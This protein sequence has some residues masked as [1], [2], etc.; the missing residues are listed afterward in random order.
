MAL[1]DDLL[2]RG[3]FPRELPPQFSSAKYALRMSGPDAPTLPSTEPPKCSLCASHSV[4]RTGALRRQ[5]RIPNPVHYFGLAKHIADY[6]VQ[7]IAMTGG[8]PY[9]LTKPT[10]SGERA[11]NPENSLRSRVEHRAR[12]RATGRYLLRTDITRFYSSIYTH[13]L[14]W[15]LLGKDEAKRKFANRTLGREWSDKLD[16]FVR[17]L[18]G[19]Q[20]L[21]IPTGPDI[22][23][24]LAEVVLASID[25]AIGG[26]FPNVVGLRYIDDYE[27]VTQ[28]REEAERLLSA[29]QVALR[30]FELELNGAKTLIIQLPAA[31]TEPWVSA[32][33]HYPINP[34]RRGA[35]H[36]DLSGYFDLIF[37]TMRRYPDEQVLKYGLGRL[38]RTTVRED[39]W[40]F[41]EH[42]LQQCVLSD[43]ACLPI[44]ASDVQY[45]LNR[46]HQVNSSWEDVLNG[47]V[48]RN[49]PA[50]NSN[51]CAWAIAMLL[52]LRLG[53]RS[54]SA[55]TVAREGDSITAL[56]G[57]L[58][59]Q[60]NLAKSEDFDALR[61]FLTPENLYS[62]DWLMCYEANLWLWLG[63]DGSVLGRDPWFA[64]LRQGTSEQIATFLNPGGAILPSQKR[65]PEE[66]DDNVSDD[67]DD[68]DLY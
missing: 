25:V 36:E 27:F 52:Q 9:S 66:E 18:N 1:L 60:S 21:G 17:K 8:S 31:L 61:R 6:W 26:Q 39:N 4:A 42:L 24:L 32:L 28:T 12:V 40:G 5:L 23:L 35:Q 7:L 64:L 43:P 63:A 29:L 51:E 46:G 13:S 14:P 54:E 41:F 48:L 33:R 65:D 20:T 19:D 10:L 37:D 50:G 38:S 47:T 58:I 67:E 3:Y 16:K 56:M 15:A 11:I 30:N 49:M 44:V 55:R 57:L 62:S 22:S 59:A 53:L 45:Y 34:T 68:F 2:S